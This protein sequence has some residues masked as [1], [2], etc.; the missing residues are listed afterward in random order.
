MCLD[1]NIKAAGV[2]AAPSTG[3][4]ARGLRGLRGLVDR[5]GEDTSRGSVGPA[6]A[7]PARSADDAARRQNH[8]VRI[9]PGPAE[10]AGPP[11]EL[12]RNRGPPIA[13]TRA[14]ARARTRASHATGLAPTLGVA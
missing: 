13:R 6:W 11:W 14:R 5:A 9:K 2:A 4:R 7:A 8:S 1:F 12:R 10:S 3:R